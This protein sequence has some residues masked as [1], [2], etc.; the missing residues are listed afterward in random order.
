MK[1]MKKLVAVTVA[2][3]MILAMSIPGFAAE[4]EKFDIV[5]DGTSGGEYEAYQ[6]FEGDYYNGKLS[7]IEWGTGVTDGG[8]T[9]FGN[10][11]AKAKTILSESDAKAFAKALVD[12]A[13][14]K[15][16]IAP[17]VSANGKVF[18]FAELEP[19]YYLVK[20]KDGTVTGHESYT[21]YIIK[22]VGDVN[23][24]PKSDIPSFN[25]KVDDVND[26]NTTEN[27]VV[28]DDSAD[29]DIGDEIPFRLEGTVAANYD[30]YNSYYYVFHD[31]E[32]ASLTFQEDTVRVFVDGKE[33]TEGFVVITNP[34]DGCTF[35]V[36]FAD[37]KQIEE[38][39]ASS[40][41]QVT[42]TSILNENAVLGKQ[43]NVNKAKLEFS[44]NPN[45]E[46]DGKPTG[47]TDWDNVI[48]FTYKVVVNKYAEKVAEGNELAG[49]EFTLYK[50]L[51]DG[52]K[53]TIGV[54][55]LND[56]KT[57]EFKGL[58]DGDYVLEE[59]VAPDG[60]NKIKDVKFT[61]NAEHKIIWEGIPRDSVLV[62]LE[63]GDLGT[64]EV[65]TGQITGNIVNTSGLTL[66][67]TGG[68][69]TVLFY[70]AGGLLVAVAAVVLISK[71]RM[72]ENN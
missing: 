48:V 60:F 67:G 7:N 27:A 41:I 1:T 32:E 25:K 69:G 9:H 17:T 39:E 66:P 56:G 61:V 40:T 50:K 3:V 35:E 14:L 38:V 36:K 33:I 16:A 71:K 15:G 26:S 11:E 31:V 4:D 34:T 59:T 65:S 5:I 68:I 30:D 28:W 46:G 58:D 54:T 29:Y 55:K 45:H 51:A 52:S 62:K 44:N 8:K 21:S 42:Y 63:A 23:M 57:F 49:A 2:L 18:T 24:K 10:A 43:G 13:Y 20:D 12:G 53:K 47:E 19:G 64:G 70:V 72:E 37:L 6:I 22:V